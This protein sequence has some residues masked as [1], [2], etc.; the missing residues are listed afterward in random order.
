MRLLNPK[1]DYVFKR[2]FA[3]APQLLTALINAIRSDDEVLEVIEVLNPRIDPEELAGK[4]IVLDILAK[5]RHGR[6]LNVEMQ[7]KRFDPWSARSTYYLASALTKQITS[8]E[9]YA[10]LKPVIGIH[11]LDFD[12]FTE[13]HQL[14]QAHWCFEMRDRWQPGTKLGS[15]LELNIIELG[16]ADRLHSATAQSLDA[17]VAFFEHWSEDAAMNQVT[18][19]PV[20]QALNM[21]KDL[22]AD[23]E[24]QHR[25]MVRERALHDERTLIQAAEQR[26]KLEGLEDALTKMIA[27]GIAEAQA[28]TILGL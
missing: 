3:V 22:S 2:L 6:L 4:F 26:G 28:R 9:S 13:P 14:S 7:V 10:D 12:L 15:E 24:A 8:G 11:L 21:L 17:W 19:P 16:K 25:A 20:Q 1:N 5:D 27:S 23:A 18:Y